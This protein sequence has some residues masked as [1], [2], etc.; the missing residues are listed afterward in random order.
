M[1]RSIIRTLVTF[2]LAAVLLSRPLTAGDDAESA[3]RL[4]LA[5]VEAGRDEEALSALRRA[6][7]L[8]SDHVDTWIELGRT[9]SRLKRWDE[10][11]AAYRRAL[12]LDP[13]SAR[14]WHNLGNVQFRIGEFASAADSYG[15][16]VAIEP[17]YLLAAFHQGWALRQLNRVE[18]AERAFRHCL[19]VPARNDED[20]KTL[21]DCLFGLGSILHRREDYASSAE[22]MERVLKIF[23][24]HPEARYYLAIAYRQLG[25]PEEAAR[26]FALHRELLDTLR[27]EDP[28][29]APDAP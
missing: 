12:E 3:Y 18:D 16:A 6:A 20:R 1:V 4:G 22:L 13:A 24:R 8:R 7:E 2:A 11:S 25:R 14:A 21:T 23:P 17:D 28:I 26:Q 5:A 27:A 9:Y 15:R 19:E 29:E 10:S